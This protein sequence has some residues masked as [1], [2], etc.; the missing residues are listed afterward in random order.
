M[1][2]NIEDGKFELINK[3]YERHDQLPQERNS[4]GFVEKHVFLGI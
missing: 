1:G 3:I 2:F 4:D